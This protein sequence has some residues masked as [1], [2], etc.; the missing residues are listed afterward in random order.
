MPNGPTAENGLE[1]KNDSGLKPG[2]TNIKGEVSILGPYIG[3]L[4][5]L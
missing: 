1:V 5:G 4:T 3:V 2:G